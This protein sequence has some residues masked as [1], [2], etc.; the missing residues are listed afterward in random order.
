MTS[1]KEISLDENLLRESEA[2]LQS[3]LP[4]YRHGTALDLDDSFSRTGVTGTV[5]LPY[6]SSCGKGKCTR[7]QSC[8]V[9]RLDSFTCNKVNPP[10]LR[11][12]V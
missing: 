11:Y 8:A 5:D 2:R 10:P 7:Q 9:P 3:S 12:A 6:E 1:I 4:L